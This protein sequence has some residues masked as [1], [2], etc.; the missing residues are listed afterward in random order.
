MLGSK[1][2]QVRQGVEQARLVVSLDGEEGEVPGTEGLDPIG[3]R[4]CRP[5][6]RSL[7]G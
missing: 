2:L 1:L 7:R 4:L 6:A 3:G 5:R